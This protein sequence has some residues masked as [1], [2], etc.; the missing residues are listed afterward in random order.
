[1]NRVLHRVQQPPRRY[2]PDLDRLL[3]SCERN[4]Q[5]LTALL[6]IGD[7]AGRPG[8]RR[9]LELVTVEEDRYTTTLKVLECDPAV[10]SSSRWLQGSRRM[11]VRLYHDARLAEVLQW[12]NR[13]V[14][15]GA[16]PYPNAQMAQRDEKQRM[17]D[18][19][20]EW[21]ASCQRR[22]VA[23]HCLREPALT[24]LQAASERLA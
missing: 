10:V 9:V 17:T 5:A 7:V 13:R 3:A 24:H 6:A 8:A 15:Q 4:F 14:M 23:I 2:V 11:I 12:H 19:L 1:M 22:Q 21:L 20:T 18:F 16:Y